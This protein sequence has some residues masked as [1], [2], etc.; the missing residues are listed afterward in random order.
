M[1]DGAKCAHKVLIN[2]TSDKSECTILNLKLFILHFSMREDF[3]LKN[4]RELLKNFLPIK[5][6]LKAR[7]KI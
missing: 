3:L 5:S 6:N 2:R 1:W 4:L 7:V